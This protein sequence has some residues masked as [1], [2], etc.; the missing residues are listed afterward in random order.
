MAVRSPS[1]GRPDARFRRAL[2]LP[3]TLYLIALAARGLTGAM[4]P[5]PAYPD[6]TY[7]FAVAQSL[8]TG[9]GFSVDFI[10]NFVDVGGRLPA[11]PTLPIPSN[12]HWMP[13][14]ALI[15]VPFLLV[16][17]TA[18]FVSLIPFV[19]IGATAAPITWA[20]ADDA[21]LRGRR[22]V[23]PALM[24]IVPG[25]VTPFLAQPDNF[26]LFMPLGALALWLCARGLRGDVRA[27]VLGGL[28]V[29]LATLARN[30]GVL[31]GVPFALGWLRERFAGHR[32]GIASRAT[33]RASRLPLTAAIG[34]ALL[35]LAAMG[36]WYA[37]QLAVFGSLSPS[38]SNGRILWITSYP[39]LY[40][41]TGD[42][43]FASFLAQGWAP[44]LM[45]RLAGFGA[46]LAI[47]AIGPFLFFLVP[48][49][50]W[51]SWARRCSGFFQPWFLYGGLLLLLSGILF[52]VHV[53]YGTFLHSAVA[54]IP[55]GYVL[56]VEGIALAV[57]WASGRRRH[58]N[59]PM[60][61]RV[62]TAFAIATLWLGGA[63]ATW[64]ALVDWDRDAQTRRA[65]AVSVAHLAAPGD[66]L[67]SAD[68][69]AY[70]YYTGLGGVVT[71]EDQLDTVESVARAYRIRWLVLEPAHIV[72]S[73][74]RVLAGA[75]P[76]PDWLVPVVEGPGTG[77]AGTIRPA[78]EGVPS[79]ND[80]LPLFR[81][82]AVCLEA[83]ES[84]AACQATQP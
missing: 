23:A 80:T 21:G 5:E 55:H 74:A 40:S 58:W 51:G 38:A 25:A 48:F 53:P 75:T 43:T 44:L 28:V 52:A 10:W 19:L 77:L 35:F 12:A 81:I 18:P 37:R 66:R 32:T 26:A 14:A 68:P 17:G 16:L 34:C 62:F 56:G 46:A 79:G 64:R 29:G 73:L 13:L 72:D 67:M 65:V 82:Y 33:E 63:A 7:Y 24:A 78:G 3:L 9:H 39:Q 70:W 11:D 27:F 76:P 30:D 42:P 20:I 8:A 61:T 54:L 22:A 45:S 31:L 36:P 47:L 71:P 59:V 6:A 1:G 4:H 69:G 49:V 50:V 57:V 84:R 41:V 83:G 2:R 60:A 15:Q